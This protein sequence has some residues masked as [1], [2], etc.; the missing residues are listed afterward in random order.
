VISAG[1][2]SVVVRSCDEAREVMQE[3]LNRE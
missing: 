1:G 3:V 2:T